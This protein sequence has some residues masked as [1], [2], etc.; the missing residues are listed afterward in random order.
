MGEV[1]LYKGC[2]SLCSLRSFTTKGFLDV[3][4]KEA[5]PFYRSSSGVRLCWELEKPQEPKGGSTR[6]AI[7]CVR[8]VPPLQRDFLNIPAVDIPYRACSQIRTHHFEG[9]GVWTLKQ[10]TSANP[11]C[12]VVKILRSAEI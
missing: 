6:V 4:Q 3:I 2:H 10:S 9:C 1:P 12:A 11:V 8:C 7:R 5:W